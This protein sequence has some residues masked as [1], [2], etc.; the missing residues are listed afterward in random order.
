MDREQAQR[1][2]EEFVQAP[3]LRRHM[4]AVDAA[5]RCYAERLDADIETWGMAGRL[6]DFD[7]EIHPTLEQHPRTGHRSCAS[8]AARSR[9][10]RRSCP[11][12]PKAP[13]SSASTDRLR[14]AGLR[15]DHRP[16]HRRGPHSPRQG[17]P[18]GQGSS[19]SR[20]AGSHAPSP[21]GSTASTSPRRPRT[22]AGLLRR[23]ARALA[24]CP[25][26]ARAMQG[27]AAGLELDGRLAQT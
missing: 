19:R 16:D 26:R 14:S 8:A 27:A 7:W 15:R 5:M 21:P 24:A 20:S 18:A 2:V 12:T 11:T 3:G 4:A 9:S 13:A 6:H 17:R 25:E 10:S 22:S 23:R 1:I